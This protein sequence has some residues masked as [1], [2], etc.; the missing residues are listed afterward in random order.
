MEIKVK[1]SN[2]KLL[3]NNKDIILNNVADIHDIA[4]NDPKALTTK[5]FFG[6]V[7]DVDGDTRLIVVTPVRSLAD[8][9]VIYLY[10]WDKYAKYWHRLEKFTETRTIFDSYDECVDF[11]MR[12]ESGASV[13][14]ESG[15][16]IADELLDEVEENSREDAERKNFDESCE[17]VMKYERV[18]KIEEYRKLTDEIAKLKGELKNAENHFKF[19]EED[20]N[21]ALDEYRL[22]TREFERKRDVRDTAKKV[23]DEWKKKIEE[24]EKRCDE[25]VIDYGTNDSDQA[26]I[27]GDFLRKCFGE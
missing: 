14:E 26:A 18:M 3:S 9:D 19:A 1:Y 22:I 21:K 4:K 8:N 15:K 25:L 13:Y 16:S 23:K 11:Y 20:Y 24:L 12:T 10:I 6:I 7:K 5:L 17:R 2:G 27:W